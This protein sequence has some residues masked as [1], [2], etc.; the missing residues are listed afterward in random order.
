[1]VDVEREAHGDAALL[2]FEQRVGD[3]P[4]RVL[5]QIEVVE[6]E[7]EALLRAGQEVRRELGDLERGLTPVRQRSDVDVRRSREP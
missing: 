3:E 2:R 4:R 1:M 7:I 5:L 6:R